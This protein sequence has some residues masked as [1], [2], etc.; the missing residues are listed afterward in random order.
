MMAYVHCH[1]CNWSQ[2]DF[3]DF[4]I[5]R[6]GYWG[7]WGYNPI[8][9]FLSYA[10]GQNG[11]LRPRW[12]SVPAD[13]A[14]ERGLRRNRQHSWTCL[15][16]HFRRLLRRFWQQRWYTYAH[17]KGAVTVNGGRWPRCPK[18]GQRDLDID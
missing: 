16:R 3:W 15:A 6:Y 8:S 9:L 4:G 7:R 17:W 2:D 13:Y 11:Y 12:M 14:R 5:R 18:C 10:T 1:N